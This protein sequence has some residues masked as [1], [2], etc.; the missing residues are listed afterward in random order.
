MTKTT[1]KALQT[2]FSEKRVILFVRKIWN[3]IINST[4]IPKYQKKK[5]KNEKRQNKMSKQ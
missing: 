4:K 3:Q 5:K 1:H 2:D